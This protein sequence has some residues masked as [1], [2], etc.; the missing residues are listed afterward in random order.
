MK[1]IFK[2]KMINQCKIC[3]N[4]L[5]NEN[6]VV[7]EMM[8]GTRENF[9]YFRCSS[10]GCLQ[11]TESPKNME[12]YYSK[13]NYYSF[14]QNDINNTIAKKLKN[15]LYKYAFSLGL[16][17]FLRKRVWLKLLSKEKA[18]KKTSSI[19]DV[20]CGVGK[21]LQ[22]M[23]IWGFKN[24]T[25]IDP[26]IKKDIFYSSGV[27]I[28]KQD[29]FNH[30]EKYDLIMLHHSFEHMNNPLLVLKAL[31]KML[32]HKGTLLIRIP[33]SDSFAWRKYG[34]NWVQI[35][36][37]RHFFLHTTRSMTI[38]SKEAGFVLKQIV[39]DSS[40][41][42]FLGSENNCRDISSMETSTHI[43]H[44]KKIKKIARQLNLMMDGDQA[45]FIFKKNNDV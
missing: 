11:I 7:R 19:L 12:K 28:L 23:N 40:D 25:G 34:S 3:K 45:C 20:G 5:G 37:P 39:H 6:F 35:D 16:N 42:Q 41:A 9:I 18:V 24:L 44:T 36:A 29:V 38:L 31:H 32:N 27:K 30:S 2:K 14:Q 4:S 10:C 17:F 33:V 21:L 1:E 43:F 15:S 26:F 13:E 8:F 22:E